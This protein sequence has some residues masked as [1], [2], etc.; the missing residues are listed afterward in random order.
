MDFYA[1]YFWR[2]H[3]CIFGV[4]W[5][6]NC[7]RKSGHRIHLSSANHSQK[8]KVLPI[9]KPRSLC[10]QSLL[11]WKWSRDTTESTQDLTSRSHVI[12][13]SSEE[14]Y[15]I[16]FS[17]SPT[18]PMLIS[19][20]ND[21]IGSIDLEIPI[22]QLTFAR[23]E[24]KINGPTIVQL[25]KKNWLKLE[26]VENASVLQGL[27]ENTS[28]VYS[29]DNE[30]GELE[31]EDKTHRL[32]VEEESNTLGDE[33]GKPIFG[34][35]ETTKFENVSLNL[36][37]GFSSKPKKNQLGNNETSMK[38]VWS[39]MDQLSEN[40]Q[41][42]EISDDWFCKRSDGIQVFYQFRPKHTHHQPHQRSGKRTKHRISVRYTPRQ[43]WCP[44]PQDT[45][46][47]R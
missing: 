20:T 2:N 34:I 27:L 39:V 11:W 36:F 38:T 12:C 41:R 32:W 17:F 25:G 16:S 44:P 7:S 6:Q 33:H 46:L 3:D 21:E 47:M 43:L 24:I 13:H 15:A 42:R 14:L 23:D 45:I 10:S 29:D 26:N 5:A 30:N 22:Q 18:E 35:M 40:K 1:R 4:S 8:V 31:E 37:R 19:A 28:N 9:W